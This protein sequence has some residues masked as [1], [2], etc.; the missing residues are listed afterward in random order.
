MMKTYV[1]QALTTATEQV[2]SP[3]LSAE[4]SIDDN[5]PDIVFALYYGKFQASGIKVKRITALIE[6]RINSCIDYQVLLSEIHQFYLSQR[7]QVR[8][9][10]FSLQINFLHNSIIF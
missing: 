9:I 7:A 3:K 5:S 8:K 1:I 6:E 10:L 4:L 2:L